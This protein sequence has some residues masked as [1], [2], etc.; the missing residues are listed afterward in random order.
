MSLRSTRRR[1]FRQTHGYALVGYLSLLGMSSKAAARLKKHSFRDNVY[2]RLGVEPFIM[3]NIPFT[4][5]SATLVW[6][7]VRE[8]MDEASQY[9]V[10]IV[11]LQRAVGRRL[12]EISGAEAGM[13][14]SGSAAAMAVATAACIA[15]TDPLKIRALP[16][17]EG[18]RNEVV[19]WGGRSVFDNAIR[20]AGGQLKVIET[21]A[22]LPGAIS[23][24][25]AML[26][27]GYPADPVPDNAPPLE[28][29]LAV[30]KQ[31]GVPVFVD[32]A[33]GIPPVGNLK[34]YAKMGVDLYAFS[35]GKGL[36]GPQCSGLLFGRKDL[37]EAALM[38][39]S[40]VEG[41]VCRPMKVGKE[42][43]IGCLTA[44]EK[45]LTIDLEDLYRQQDKKLQRIEAMLS[46]VPGVRTKTETRGGS[47]RFRQLVVEWDESE[48]S[49]STGE[50]G[51]RLRESSPSIQVLSDYNPYVIRE[52]VPKPDVDVSGDRK[53]A[54]E[55]VTVYALGLQKGEEMIVGRRLREV[56]LGARRG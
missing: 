2:T 52:R 3:A 55:T 12:A 40:P 8:A 50:C 26:Y 13:V 19:M 30:C 5:L 1:F 18:M 14:T 7:E 22:D 28:K 49:I 15:G 44:V 25:T 36:Q 11:Q 6:P 43:I 21:L 4:F 51:R 46:T 48:I 24:R 35:G 31:R 37:I 54:V 38:N 39:S 34:R 41:A 27:T 23:D 53:K 42:E 9:F 56:L 45:W 20:L 29:I 33:G 32:A 10:D 17:S 16:D 47:N